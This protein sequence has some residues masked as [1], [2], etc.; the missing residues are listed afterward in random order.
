MLRGSRRTSGDSGGGSAGGAQGVGVDAF[1]L[2]HMRITAIN[3]I[4]KVK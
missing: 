1:A 4:I 3:T 2:L